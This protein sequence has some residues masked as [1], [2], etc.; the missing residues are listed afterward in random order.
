MKR[1]KQP[2][3]RSKTRRHVVKGGTTRLISPRK[4]LPEYLDADSSPIHTPGNGAGILR[5]DLDRLHLP[6]ALAEAADAEDS[7]L[8]PG[9]F[10]LTIITLGIIFI[11][12]ITWFVSQMPDK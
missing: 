2:K 5:P 8:I 12:I 3:S 9:R 7:A 1:S 4:A 6:G 11:A 10:M